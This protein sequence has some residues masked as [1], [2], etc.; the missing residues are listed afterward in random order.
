MTKLQL[1]VCLALTT[2]C[3]ASG[4]AVAAPFVAAPHAN[5]ASLVQQTD[6]RCYWR[7]GHRV[8]RHFS[9]YRDYGYGYNYGYAPGIFLGFGGFGHHHGGFG[10]HHH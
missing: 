4:S 10:H 8:C 9:Y 5:G 3:G 6:Y 7:Y 2:V 1:V